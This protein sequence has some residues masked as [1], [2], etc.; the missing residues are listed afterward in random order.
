MGARGVLVGRT[1][2][3]VVGMGQKKDAQRGCSLSES[4]DHIS[5]GKESGVSR[6]VGEEQESAP[7]GKRA[8][9]KVAG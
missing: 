6:W 4:T 7:K 9:G 8:V 5:F 2:S 1:P 3:E